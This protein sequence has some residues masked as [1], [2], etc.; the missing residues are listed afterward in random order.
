MFSSKPRRRGG[1]TTLPSGLESLDPVATRAELEVI[2]DVL[3][4][5]EWR[6]VEELFPRL[7]LVQR[8]IAEANHATVASL[9]ASPVNKRAHTK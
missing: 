5:V 8:R 1:D 4:F 3:T 7:A 6:I 9:F 2:G